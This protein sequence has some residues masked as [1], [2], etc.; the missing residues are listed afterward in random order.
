M[1]KT[2]N[3]A[4]FNAGNKLSGLEWCHLFWFF[5]QFRTIFSVESEQ[6]EHG[7]S[8]LMRIPRQNFG[9]YEPP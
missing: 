6:G 7:F 4:F 9:N 5:I 8:F 3:S 1:L 2:R